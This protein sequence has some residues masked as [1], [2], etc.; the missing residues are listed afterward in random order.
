MVGTQVGQY[1]IV[2][3]LGGGSMGTV[4]EAKHLQLGGRAA[5][6]VLKPE[7]A[8][9]PET[10]TRFFNE[11]KAVNH[12]DHPG[13]VRI[14]DFGSLPNGS[15][16]LVMELLSGETLAARLQARSRLSEPEALAII[17]QL[18]SILEAAHQRGIVHRDVKPSNIMLEPGGRVRLLDYF[19][20]KAGPCGN[21]DTCLIPPV[22]FDGTV[23]VQKLLSAIYRVDPFVGNQEA[24]VSV[25]GCHRTVLNSVAWLVGFIATA[26]RPHLAIARL[27]GPPTP[28]L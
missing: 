11:A 26:R 13:L 3:E 18:A 28:D 15:P 27:F 23:P 7:L 16:Y 1:A 19:G 12:I 2:R 4:Y 6:K 24:C 25:G 17:G 14:F 5:I 21:C 22:S 10:L 9:S 8:S 20:E